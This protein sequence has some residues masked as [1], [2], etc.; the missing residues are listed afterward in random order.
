MKTESSID[1]VDKYEHQARVLFT[2]CRAQWRSEW[3]LSIADQ[4]I[5]ISAIAEALRE[6]GQNAEL[7]AA[8][9]A[10]LAFW[11]QP[12]SGAGG[13]IK[14]AQDL[15]IIKNN[16]QAAIAKAESND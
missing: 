2:K 13:N 3:R 10:C 6:Q 16:A 14:R 15:A 1:P 8:L 7:L 5:T 11:N 4:D 9:K 12:P